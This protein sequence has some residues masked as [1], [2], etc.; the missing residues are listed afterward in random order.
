MVEQQQQSQSL[1]HRFLKR[2]LVK[3]FLKIYLIH[4]RQF[5]TFMDEPSAKNVIST[6]F[7]A[8]A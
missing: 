1:V 6:E 8:Y 4:T 3:L 2:I 5:V 7:W